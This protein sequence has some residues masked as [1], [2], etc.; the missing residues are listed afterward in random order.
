MNLESDNM[1]FKV[2][3][4]MLFRNNT[5]YSHGNHEN[6]VTQLNDRS[7]YPMLSRKIHDSER[8]RRSFFGNTH[9]SDYCAII[10]EFFR[11]RK[12]RGRRKSPSTP[13]TFPA[14]RNAN[15]RETMDPRSGINSQSQECGKR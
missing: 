13:A 10:S 4:V 1:S 9:C 15:R 11:R 12:T 8:N 14:A 5:A 7:F 3:N 6:L 2:F